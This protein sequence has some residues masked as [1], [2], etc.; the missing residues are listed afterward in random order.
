MW[1]ATLSPYG[2]G[3]RVRAPIGIRTAVVAAVVA[4]AFADSSV[5][6]L[7]LPQ[8]YGR[9]DTTITG[10]AWVLTAYNAAVAA[11]AIALVLLVRHR[12]S[13]LVLMAAGAVLGLLWGS[14]RA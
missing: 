2:V 8:L 12:V 4:L 7:A 13:P 1:R 3:G 6:V 10:V 5:V 14:W 9:F 11:A